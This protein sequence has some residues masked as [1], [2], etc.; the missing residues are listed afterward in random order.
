M[1]YRD[2]GR[3]CVE[4]YTNKLQTLQKH[5]Q[6]VPLRPI[7][8]NYTMLLKDV[9]HF[10]QTCCQPAALLELFAAVQ[11]N[12]NHNGSGIETG[13][14][15]IAETIKRIE[16]WISN[17]AQFVHH[18]LAKY[19]P[20]YM[21]FVVPIR[22]SIVMM[23]SGLRGLKHCLQQQQMYTGTGATENGASTALNALLGNLVAFPSVG[24]LCIL[25]GQSAIGGS[26]SRVLIKS[27][28]YDAHYLK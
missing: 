10:L 27:E 12:L 19:A 26:V 18:T 3:D 8:C 2:L 24:G 21:D 11:S 14:S 13:S 20:Y 5:S 16:L 17:A 15:N 28:R 9:T 7:A 25:P 23:E 6:L 4:P 22:N 1:K